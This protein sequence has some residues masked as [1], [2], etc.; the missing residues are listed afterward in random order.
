[1]SDHSCSYALMKIRRTCSPHGD[2]MAEANPR[3][4]HK[5]RATNQGVSPS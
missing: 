3:Y 4:V 2:L 1:M 5:Q